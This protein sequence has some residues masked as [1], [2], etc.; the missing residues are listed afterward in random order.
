MVGKLPYHIY[1]IE[2][3]HIGSISNVEDA[4]RLMAR[5]RIVRWGARGPVLWSEGFEDFSAGESYDKAARIAWDRLLMETD[6]KLS[7]DQIREGM[8]I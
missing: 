1:T 4:V 7:V 8:A 6:V 2:G 5:G 3:V